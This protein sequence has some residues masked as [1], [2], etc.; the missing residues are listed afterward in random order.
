[1]E[2][3][4]LKAVVEALLLASDRPL[5]AEEMK[6]AFDE[7][8]SAGDLREQLEILTAEY[9][10][11]NRGIRLA[12]IAGGYQLVTDEKLSAYLKRFCQSREKKKFSQA[13]LE[14]LSV[15][16]YR[17]PVTRADIEFIRGVN[18]DGALQTLVD[19]NMVQVVGRKEVPGRPMLYGTTKEFL[20]RF[21]LN[22]VK[23]LPPL[24]EF[25]EKD[26]DQNLLPPEM[27]SVVEAAAET[28]EETENA[29][30]ETAEEKAE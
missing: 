25:T 26:I 28:Q 30:T 8:V 1:M 17:Q 21:G 4:E 14:T 7:N 27:R 18:V 9:E 12:Q 2:Q 20:E 23:E 24:A 6:Q 5:T 13:T 22:T 19:K 3:N 16:A 10:S 11:Q 15:I 29:Q